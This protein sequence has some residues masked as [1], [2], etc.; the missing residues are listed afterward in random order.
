L[1]GVIR[2]RAWWPTIRKDIQ[3]IAGSCP[4]CQIA[5]PSRPNLEREAAQHLVKKGI[6]PF[7]RWGIDLIRH[8]PT[9]PNGNR[10]IITVIDHATSW[11]VAKAV[12]NAKDE[13]LARFLHEE[14]FVN[15]GVFEELLL[16]NGTNLLSRVVESYVKILKAKHCTTTPNHPRTNGKN[17]NMNGLLGKMLMK[18]LMGKPTRL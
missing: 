13:M 1:L 18:Y 3:A 10:W 16:D 11:V 12:P 4:N 7:K 6:Q 9:T 14:I 17:E 15:Y 5:K 8:L 2:T